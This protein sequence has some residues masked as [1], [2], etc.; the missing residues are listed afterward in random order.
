MARTIESRRMICSL[1]QIEQTVR[2]AD[3]W[4]RITMYQHAPLPDELMQREA[5]DWIYP[6]LNGTDD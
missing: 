3:R 2:K 5:D 6:P 4:V 1:N